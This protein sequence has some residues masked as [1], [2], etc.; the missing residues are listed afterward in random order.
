VIP[1]RILLKGFL[2]Y[3]DEQEVILDGSSLWMMAGLN[4]SGKSAIFDAMTFALFGTHRG[5]SQQLVE[6]INHDSDKMLVEFDFLLDGQTYQ[7]RRTV[8]RR[9]QGGASVTQQVFRLV[10]PEQPGGTGT[11]EAIPDT[12]KKTEF[13]A[14]VREHIGLTYETFTSS[15]L[16]LQ[17]R[18]EKLLDSTAS[19]RFEVLAGIVDLDRYRRLHDR[20]DT[21]RKELKARVQALEHQLQGL[22][23][24]TEIELAEVDGRIADAES[25]RSGCQAELD[26]LQEL[27]RQAR[28]WADLLVRRAALEE[29]WKAAEGI[30]AESEAI[31][32]DLRRLNELKDILPHL[33]TAADRRA[34]VRDS[35]KKTEH[36]TAQDQTLTEKLGDS[37]HAIDQARKKQESIRKTLAN[38]EQKH[39][40][41]N[42][43]L[44]ELSTVLSQVKLCEQQ[45][46]TL[47]RQEKDLA[48]FPADLAERVAQLRLQGEQLADVERAL[49]LLNRLHA[50]RADLK[51]ART[52][53][54]D[55]AR[56][57]REVRERGEQ[58]KTQHAALATTLAEA[59][60]AR[61]VADE[62]ATEAR[63]LLHQAQAQ[64]KDF[65][66]LEG[67]QICR[68]CGQPL[69]PGHFEEEK[70]KR[71]KAR[72]EAQLHFQQTER[73]QRSSHTEETQAREALATCDAALTQTREEFREY[74]REMD[75]T[76]RDVERLM[77]ECASAFVDLPRPFRERVA[78]KD[79]APADW[80]A[81]VYPTETDLAELREESRQLEAVRKQLRETETQHA[82]MQA[83]TAQREVTRQ[84]LSSLE[85]EL[86]QDV[87]AIRRKHLNLE[88]S[89]SALAASIK[90]ARDEERATSLEIE[91]LGKDKASLQQKK[92]DTTGKLTTEEAQRKIYQE[93]VE[94]IRQK[95][96]DEW[97]KAVDTA[98]MAAIY[99]WDGEKAKLLQ[100]DTEGKAQRLQQT[101]AALESLK[102][103]RAEVETE[104][105][106]FPTEARA[107]PEVVQGRLV[108]T[109]ATMASCESVLRD[110]QRNRAVLDSQRQ[111]RE[112]A[113]KQLLE[114]QAEH[115]RY[116]LLAQLLGRDRLQRHLVRQAERQVVDHA[117][118]VLDRLSGGQLYLRLRGSDDGE[119]MADKALEL[120]AYNRS[121]GQ[122]PINVAFLS[123]SQRFRVAVAL[124]LG[125]GQYASRQHRP[126][127]SVIID[128]GFGCL[129]RQGRQ[130]MI[131]ELQNLRGQLRCILLVSHQEEFA[132][133]FSDGYLFELAD[134]STRVKR[135]QR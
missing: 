25:Q 42:K 81:T 5:G 41:V 96:P 13:N 113:Q 78:G 107:K 8:Q 30:L 44:R 87:G 106:R 129:D 12:S 115:H 102:Q 70:R 117:N 132:D 15:V 63:T 36:L 97:R 77:A 67:A 110:A 91:R 19:G 124:A 71:E 18:A 112:Q 58:L 56:M 65:L 84:T 55:C 125:L 133:A 16:L 17:G 116:D 57:D 11:R 105:Q 3:R 46:E 39:R 9:A 37:E 76:R 31:Q 93:E 35:L 108:S 4:G 82:K 21:R 123:G 66:N 80:L 103:S 69:T 62:K 121:T 122:A 118:A 45:R 100:A 130:V 88:S 61:L 1:L 119:V 135:F 101:M 52:Q 89:E 72:G 27:E 64:L 20:T 92:A 109:R 98:D 79:S 47:T 99:A 75:Q 29:R 51:R 60:R 95:L 131:Q 7:V 73:A 53:E 28:Q 111:Q 74:K 24:V 126:I 114:Q 83:L 49:P 2:C 54:Q 120:E 90:A 86:P 127:E 48:A 104:S 94:R 128:E 26:R 14:W 85:A 50:Q 23:T 6:L 59:E 10:S 134:G 34:K 38:D 32:K 33:M 40:E 22:P 68:S 43:S